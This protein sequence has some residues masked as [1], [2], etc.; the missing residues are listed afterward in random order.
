MRKDSGMNKMQRGAQEANAESDAIVG[1]KT[2]RDGP[3]G[4]RHEPLR[5]SEATALLAAVDAADKRRAELMPNEQAAI[6]MMFEAHQRLRELGWNDAVYCPKDGSEFDAIEP[7]STGI[8]RCH[9]I[10]EWPNG[11]WWVSDEHDMYPSRPVLYRR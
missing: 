6:R 3:L 8:H 4:F 9:Y 11:S 1:H 10:G 2:Y 7:G 5:Q